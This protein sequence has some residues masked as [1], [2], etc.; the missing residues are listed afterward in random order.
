MTEL[1]DNDF[2]T[3]ILN[4]FSV[5]N[6]LK[7]NMGTIMRE[8]K[9]KIFF[10]RTN[11]NSRDKNESI[12]NIETKKSY[13][14]RLITDKISWQRVGGDKKDERIWIDGIEAIKT[15]AQSGEKK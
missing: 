8:L 12:I 6:E 10:K 3:A 13:L 9:Q 15:P 2:K 1:E 7:D 11:S 14:T 5:L 4:P